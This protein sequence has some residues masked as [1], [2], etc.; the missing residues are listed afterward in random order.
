MTRKTTAKSAVEKIPQPHGGALNSGGTLGN[1]GGSGRP[2][3]A[4]R[5]VALEGAA[6]AIPRLVAQLNSK[7]AS[8]VQGAADKLLKYGLGTQSDI[9]ISEDDVRERLQKSIVMI[10]RLAPE[11]LAKRILSEMKELWT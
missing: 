4:V 11:E 8:V 9:K 6:K 1:K 5:A 10:C 3:S 7:N 2:P